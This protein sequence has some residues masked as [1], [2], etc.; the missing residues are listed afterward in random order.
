MKMIELSQRNMQVLILKTF[1]SIC[2][3]LPTGSVWGVNVKFLFLFLLLGATL[4]DKGRGV[5][6]IIIGLLPAVTLILIFSLITEFNGRY[7]LVS[8]EQ[9]KDL[10]VFFLMVTLGYALVKPENRYEVIV[11]T[12]IRCLVV[13]GLFKILI[14]FYAALSGRGVS[15]IVQGISTF[16]NTS[17]MTMESDDVVVSRINFMSDY[18]IPAALYLSLREVLIK[19]TLWKEWGVIFILFSS[20]II[21]MSRFL[22]AAG[23]LCLFL[24]LIS[25]YKKYK[26]FFII[27]VMVSLAVFLL[28]LPSVQDLIEFRFLSKGVTESDLTRT[29]QYNGIVKHFIEYPLLGNGI[30][31]YIP[32]LIRSHLSL[33]SY[34]LQ[35][36]ALYMQMGII[37]ASSIILIVLT[38]LFSQMK[39]LSLNLSISYIVLIALW[40]SGGF[41]NPVIISSTGGVSF[42][43]IYSMPNALK[44]QG[45]AT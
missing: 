15:F 26:S 8:V 29:L 2:V 24:A 41:F 12:I 35:I 11:K 31:Y 20:L 43:L 27:C 25:N 23:F 32:D 39:G 14:F 40:L 6:K 7:T 37:G 44:Y 45:E 13:L 38:I 18:L 28:S 21:S 5:V 36:P 33:Y 1:L 42:L 3:L 34:E 19:K 9:T 30:G 4:L 22:W 10:L 16:F 17:L